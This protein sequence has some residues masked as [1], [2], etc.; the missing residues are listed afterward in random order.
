MTMCKVADLVHHM[1]K[2]ADLLYQMFKVADLAYQMPNQCKVADLVYQI[3][4]HEAGKTFSSFATRKRGT[5]NNKKREVSGQN[6]RVVISA[7]YFL[8]A[9]SLA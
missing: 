3:K 4:D 1:C 6:G 8:F 9:D 7:R 2:V 5:E